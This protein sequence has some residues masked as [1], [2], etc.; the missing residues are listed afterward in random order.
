[1][2]ILIGK[3]V[4]ILTEPKHIIAKLLNKVG[5]DMFIPPPLPPSHSDKYI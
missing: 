2:T 3:Y 4:Q 5:T 1:M